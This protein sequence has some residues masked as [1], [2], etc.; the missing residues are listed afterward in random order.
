MKHQENLL[1][2]IVAAA[3]VAV[4]VYYSMVLVPDPV[5][6]AVHET[7]APA[8]V[9]ASHDPSLININAASAAALDLLPGIGPVLAER[10]VEYREEHGKFLL[11][12]DLLAVEGIGKE[13]L[14]KLREYITVE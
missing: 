3:T 6:V 9:S 4:S 1:L 13:T 7:K 14:E 10:I 8:A 12:E 5:P 2:G 11:P